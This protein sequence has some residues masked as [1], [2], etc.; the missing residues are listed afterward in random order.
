MSTRVRLLL[1]SGLML[2]LELSLIRWSG[3]EVIHLSYFSNFVLLGSF[4]GIGLGFLRALQPDRRLPYYS[5]VALIALIVFLS[6]FPVAVN[7]AG[8]SSVIYFNLT[9]SGPPI[10]VTLPVIFLAVA[11]VMA[12]PGELVADCFKDLPRLDAYRFDLLGSLIGITAFTACAFSGTPPL[13]WFIIVALLFIVLFGVAGKLVSVTLLIATVAVFTYPLV[14]DKGVFWSPYY[15]VTTF[16]QPDGYGGQQWWVYVNGVPHQR[17]TTAATRLKGQPFYNEPYLRTPRP[18]KNVLIVGA[19]TGTDVSVALTHGVQHVDAVEIDPSILEFGKLHNPDHAYQD[20]RVTTYVNDGRAFLERTHKKYDLI[21]FALP[22]SLTLV[23]GASALR[24][25]SYLF[26]DK[27][28]RSARDHL[29]PGGAFSMYNFYRQTWLVNRL[30]STMDQTFGHPPCLLARP[31]GESLAVF[32]VGLKPSDQQCNATWQRTASV[33]S[34]STDDHPFLY[35][36]DHAGFFGI[37]GI[38]LLVLGLIVVASVVAIGVVGGTKQA[39]S[40]WHYRDLFLLGASF[41]LLETKNVTGFALYFGTTWLVNALVF[42]GVLVAVLAA[43]EVTRR[44]EVPPLRTMYA[45]LFG[46]LLLAWLVPT[47]WVLAL[48]LILRLGVAIALAFIPIMA[49]NVIFAKRFDSS[50]EPTTAFGT[51]LIGAIFGGCLEYLALATGYRSLLVVCAVLYLAAYLVTPHAESA[52]PGT[53]R[54]VL[55]SLRRS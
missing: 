11:T 38:Y 7:R 9:T 18:P 44:F 35:V 53:P 16:Q 46:G 1:A 26:T 22:D 27:A 24:L 25:E 12:G 39:R 17:L 48:P 52:T 51:N 47:S 45:V 49:A 3:A 15:Q 36:N 28:M 55:A 20:P 21:L 34:P 43:V 54:R 37:P 30:G 13:V 14:H 40:M 6:F 29:A 41:L 19:G 2:F 23:S 50:A 4:L 10:W 32:V 31:Q 33:P 8:A 5:P 42:A